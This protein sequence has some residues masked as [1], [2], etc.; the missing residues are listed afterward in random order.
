LFYIEILEYKNESTFDLLSINMNSGLIN[1]YNIS[2]TQGN[3]IPRS[4]LKQANMEMHVN[5]VKN[6]VMKVNKRNEEFY[7]GK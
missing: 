4:V 2:I 7:V 3:V 6:P 5:L 1:I